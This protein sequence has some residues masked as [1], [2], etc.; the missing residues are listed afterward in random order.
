M[1]NKSYIKI[2]IRTPV[3]HCQFWL[4]SYST[5]ININ[6]RQDSNDPSETI[7]ILAFEGEEKQFWGSSMLIELLKTPARSILAQF[8][9]V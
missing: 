1:Y 7:Q 5:N 4:D 8:R 2:K 6:R 9:F 3:R